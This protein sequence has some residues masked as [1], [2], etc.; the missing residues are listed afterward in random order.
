[1]GLRAVREAIWR[2]PLGEKSA[3]FDLM[4]W[5]HHRRDPSFGRSAQI[6]LMDEN[7]AQLTDLFEVAQEFK[8]N[9]DHGFLLTIVPNLIGIGGHAFAWLGLSHRRRIGLRLLGAELA[10]V[11]RPL[12]Q[13]REKAELTEAS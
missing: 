5:C 13:H 11:M 2:R 10:Y 6:V 12:Y 7:L 3:G 9:I 1:M 8:T 4:A